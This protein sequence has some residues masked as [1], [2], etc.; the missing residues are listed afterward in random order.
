M[1]ATF[2]MT[3]FENGTRLDL[4]KVA[5]RPRTTKHYDRRGY[6]PEKVARFFARAA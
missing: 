4:R 6:N 5:G 2:I 3:A 1:R